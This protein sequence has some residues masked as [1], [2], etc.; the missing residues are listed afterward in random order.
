ME[1]PMSTSRTFKLL[2]YS[3]GSL[4]SPQSFRR[5]VRPGVRRKTLSIVLIL[6]LLSLPVSIFPMSQL[7]AMAASVVADKDSPVVGFIKYLASFFSSSQSPQQAETM[8]DR[9][10]RVS[11]IEVSPRRF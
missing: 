2:R 10:A 1:V 6:S 5:L 9:I 11:H 3:S 8:E 7:P 4:L